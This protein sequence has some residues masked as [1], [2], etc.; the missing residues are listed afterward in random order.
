LGARGYVFA[1]YCANELANHI[2][3]GVEIDTMLDP[4]RLFWNWARKVKY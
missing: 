4:D 1:P 2:V 3:G